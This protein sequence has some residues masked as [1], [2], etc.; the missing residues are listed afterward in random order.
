MFARSLRTS[1]AFSK[2]SRNGT[3]QIEARSLNPIPPRRR[4]WS[5]DADEEQEEAVER[6]T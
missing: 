1:V 5:V 3:G 2:L 4:P 6:L